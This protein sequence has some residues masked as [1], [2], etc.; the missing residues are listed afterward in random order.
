ME[1]VVIVCGILI[2]AALVRISLTLQGI[3]HIMKVEHEKPVNREW[4]RPI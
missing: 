2:A 3:Y 4:S 1:N